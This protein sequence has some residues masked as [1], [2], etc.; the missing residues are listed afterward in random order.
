MLSGRGVS[1]SAKAEVIYA[2]GHGGQNKAY[3]YN[4]GGNEVLQDAW[5]WSQMWGDPSAAVAGDE[6]YRQVRNF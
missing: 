6:Y 5:R 3:L 1:L 2:Y 4:S